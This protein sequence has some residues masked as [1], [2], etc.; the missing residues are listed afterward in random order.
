MT[1]VTDFSLIALRDCSLAAGKQGALLDNSIEVYELVN[2]IVESTFASESGEEAPGVAHPALG[3]ASSTFFATS[4]PRAYSI[5]AT[6]ARLRAAQAPRAMRHFFMVT[7][8][9]VWVTYTL[10]LVKQPFPRC[11][12]VFSPGGA[13]VNSQGR[14]PLEDAGPLFSSPGG[15]VLCRLRAAPPGLKR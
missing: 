11:L 13:A 8:L 5:T 6:P 12:V 4:G 3:P 1:R 10:A 15:A 2:G 14:Q 7:P 9:G